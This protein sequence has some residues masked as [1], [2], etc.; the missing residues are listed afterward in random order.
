MKF[1]AISRD[2]LPHQNVELLN[3]FT[4]RWQR[5][6]WAQQRWAELA[7]M[8]TDFMESRQYAEDVR[9][10]MRQGR[11]VALT[12]NKIN[13]IVR[14][15]LGYQR[16][17]KLDIKF[18]PGNDANATQGIADV[19][20]A[21][22]KSVATQNM[23][24]FVD[25]AVFLDG[26]VTGR[27][28]YETKL[29]FSNNDLGELKRTSVDPFEVFPD[30]DT[31]TY[32]VNETASYIDRARWVS[33]DEVEH[34]FGQHAAELVR[35]FIYGDTPVGNITNAIIDDIVMP[36]RAMGMREQGLTNWWDDFYVR[37]GDFADKYRKTIRVIQMEHYR[38]EVR[39]VFIDLETGDRKV[40]PKHF[41]REKIEKIKLYAESVGNP[42]VIQPRK[43]R[44]PWVSTVIGDLIVHNAESVYDSFTLTGY[45]PYFR[46]G[47]TRGVVEDLIDPQREVNKRRSV[48]IEMI[49][50][51]ANGGFWVPENS[52]RPQEEMK[53]KRYGSTPGVVIKYRVQANGLKPEVMQAGVSPANHERL[54]KNANE[55][56]RQ[57]SGV[58]ESALGEVPNSSASGKALEA[59]QR[60]AVISIQLYMD[61]Q[62]QTKT[63]LG[64]K[65]INIFQT[66][67]T[68]PRIFRAIGED[69]KLAMHEINI[70]QTVEPVMPGQAPILRI[71][72]DITVGKYAA[73]VDPVPL[74]AT[75]QS[76]QFDE[77]MTLLE[78]LAPAL[79][80]QIGAF[81]DLIIQ[82]SSL[83]RKDDWVQRWQQVIGNSIGV[84]AD[85]GMSP[86]QGGVLG[87]PPMMAGAG[88]QGPG[89]PPQVTA[90]LGA[91]GP[92]PPGAPAGLPGGA[93][94]AP[95]DPVPAQLMPQ[96]PVA[97]QSAVASLP[98]QVLDQIIMALAGGAAPAA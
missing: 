24:D 80:G 56:I 3:L 67:Y 55:D 90:A 15:I 73:V 82:A 65:D 25:A 2:K 98:P 87:V 19:L 10:A 39:N 43:V 35:P 66:H 21:L 86:A 70:R 59:R 4:E 41:G 6:T 85:G 83:S 69:S 72:N 26:I 64:K 49:S 79:G 48:E 46:R 37:M 42:V 36:V 68:E 51:S 89:L 54:E 1:G 9:T 76:A 45:F 30:P 81:A 52:L 58:N 47:I 23:E 77:M 7:T 61:N 75:F 78:K 94:V 14:L 96:Q 57:I 27:G 91:G 12:L 74:S 8:S 33:L 28:W 92:M 93:P 20:T 50:K 60:Q 88:G 22:E 63:L 84:M 29:D 32:D 95:A 13:P 17:N 62:K 34:E 31:T 53:L 16:N 40:L 38:S 18:Q 5:A 44:V 71:M 97:P 11:R